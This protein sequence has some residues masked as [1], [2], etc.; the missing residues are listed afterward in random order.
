MAYKTYI[1]G[2]EIKKD[3]TYDE[4]YR[5]LMKAFKALHG[6]PWTEPTSFLSV[7]LDMALGE[8]FSKL[9]ASEI[10]SYKDILIVI[11]TQ[12][13]KAKYFGPSDRKPNKY[14]FDIV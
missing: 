1:I 11:D 5:S 9:R 8:V 7:H 14:L 4:R 13:N 12:S 2:F 10:M 3:D 6:F